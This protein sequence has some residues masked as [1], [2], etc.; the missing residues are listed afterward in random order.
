LNTA[1]VGTIVAVLPIIILSAEEKC[2]MEIP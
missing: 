2:K 1:G